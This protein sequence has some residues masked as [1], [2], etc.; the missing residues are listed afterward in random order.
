MRNVLSLWSCH[1]LHIRRSLVPPSA[2]RYADERTVLNMNSLSRLTT[3]PSHE[4]RQSHHTTASWSVRNS[5]PARCLIHQSCFALMLYV[6][7]H[8]HSIAHP[9][10]LG[11]FT[12]TLSHWNKLA[13]V[14]SE[15]FD[16]TPNSA[17]RCSSQ[18]CLLSCRSASVRFDRRSLI[19]P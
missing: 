10:L 16:T 2:V 13:S 19:R 4:A 14:R 8:Q 12:C 17:W 9:S 18:R 6:S 7:R 15:G 11:N 1:H 3:L 5:S